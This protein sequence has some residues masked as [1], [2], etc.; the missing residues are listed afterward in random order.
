[1]IYSTYLGGTTEERACGIALNS[2]SNVYICGSTSG[3]DFPTIKAYQK[4]LSGDV[5]GIVTKFTVPMT[6]L[7]YSTYLGGNEHDTPSDICVDSTGNV[8]VAGRTSSSNFPTLNAFQYSI[9]SSASDIF[10]TKMNQWGLIYSTFIGGGFGENGSGITIS[11]LCEV[12]V[13]GHTN[14]T[15]FPTIN[16]LQG[17]SAG[18]PGE[19]VIFKIDDFTVLT[20]TPTITPTPTTTPTITPTRTNTLTPTNTRTPTNT[21]TPTFTPSSTVTPTPTPKS[22]P[23]CSI[24]ILLTLLLIMA[25]L[26]LLRFGLKPV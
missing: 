4:N 22:V 5:D 9:A 8:Y 6:G 1:L 13:T 23:I 19:A 24:Q 18:G 20:P 7:E 16:A 25:G 15:N 12:Y 14:S 2:A 10:V 3:N 11:D 17:V 21:I 26:N